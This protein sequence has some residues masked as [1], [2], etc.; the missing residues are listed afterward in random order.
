VL[1]AAPALFAILFAGKLL[2]GKAR[3]SALRRARELPMRLPEPMHFSDATV[4]EIIQSLAQARHRI[5]EVRDTG[6]RGPGFDLGPATARVPQLERD[7]V[8][9]AQRAEYVATFLAS[10][11]LSDLRA[12]ERR[13]AERI[14]H[15]TDP[16]RG[17]LSRQIHAHAKARL[18]AA[19]ALRR[20]YEMLVDA[21]RDALGALEALPAQMTLSQLQRF[22]ACHT[23]SFLEGGDE[24]HVDED[25]QEIGLVLANEFPK[26]SPKPSSVD[27]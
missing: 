8:V 1:W 24:A 20:E 14:G 23:P 6:P 18:D 26:P 4:R 2:D 13:Q 10:N 5:G 25:A 19:T 7:I 3:Q 9:L 17:R 21:A 16:A 27:A 22:N 11:P 12:E 15:D